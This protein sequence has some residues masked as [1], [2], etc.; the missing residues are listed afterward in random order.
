MTNLLY[1][2]HAN[3]AVSPAAEQITKS[4][5]DTDKVYI[6]SAGII[7]S[8]REGMTRD[9]AAALNSIGYEPEHHV[10]RRVIDFL[11]PSGLVLC[12]DDY[13]AQFLRRIGFE[14][15][16]TLAGFA[17]EPGNIP[18]PAMVIRDMPEFN[19][20]RNLPYYNRWAFYRMMGRID[21]SD[22]TA[23]SH[24]HL[25]L[26]KRLERYVD[27]SIKRLEREGALK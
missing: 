6:A 27:L 25:D 23:V 1:V 17:G 10:P 13:Q 3:L 20:I 9:M 22:K 12:M 16:H 24:F 15:V 5:I 26:A 11:V 21:R 14:N 7:N 2:C 18:D 8:H 4:K 19:A